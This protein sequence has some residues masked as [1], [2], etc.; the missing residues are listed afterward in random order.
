MIPELLKMLKNLQTDQFF[1]IE[2]GPLKS[3]LIDT[4]LAEADA[5]DEILDF[6]H[7]V[8]LRIKRTQG[9]AISE[10]VLRLEAGD[11]EYQRVLAVQDFTAD[12]IGELLDHLR[13]LCLPL[14]PPA[15]GLSRTIVRKKPGQALLNISTTA[16]ILGLTPRQLKSLIPC[17]ETRIVEED[18]VKS[19]KEYYWDRGLVSRF[20]ALWIKQQAGRG[21]NNEDLCF[22]AENCCDG[23]RRWAHD[24]ISGFLNQ[25]KRT[26]TLPCS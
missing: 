2:T 26:L 20:E 23:D 18:G 8:T 3:R 10:F 15:T 12:E 11:F 16:K 13:P 9:L 25:R 22:I 1:Y 17:S 19:I 21:Y 7:S 5:H 4:Y 6:E 24:C 14:A